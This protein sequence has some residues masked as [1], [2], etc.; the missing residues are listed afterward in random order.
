MTTTQLAYVL[1]ATPALTLTGVLA[2]AR[3]RR[4]PTPPAD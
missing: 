3:S 1:I 4:T 2:W